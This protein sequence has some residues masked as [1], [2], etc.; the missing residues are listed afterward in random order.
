MSPDEEVDH[1]RSSTSMPFARRTSP[2]RRYPS[3]N[4]TIVTSPLSF[5]RLNRS[6]PPHLTGVEIAAVMSLYGMCKANRPKKMGA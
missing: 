6:R 4:V 1:E 2:I 5:R 3:P